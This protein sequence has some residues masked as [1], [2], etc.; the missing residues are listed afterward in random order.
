MTSPQPSQDADAQAH[1]QASTAPMTLTVAHCF[2]EIDRDP[3]HRARTAYIVV[4]VIRA[5]T[6]LA[7]MFEHGARR[8]LVARDVDAARAVRATQPHAILAG[9]VNAVAPP[10]FD[11]GNS[12]QEWSAVDVADREIL[13]ST[14]NGAHAL[15]AA[16]GGG[17]V[18]AGSL[19]NA[20]AVCAAALA[21]V[22]QLATPE[23]GGIVT[24]VCSGLGARPADDDSLCAG[25]LIQTLRD[26]ARRDH[27]GA[28]LGPGAQRALDLL[29]AQRAAFSQGEGQGADIAPRVWLAA[30]MRGTPAAQAVLAAGLGADLAWCANV[31]ASTVVPMIAGEDV[32][33]KLVIVERAPERLVGLPIGEEIR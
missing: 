18:F 14:S 31:D 1:T 4:D 29:A 27:V 28:E 20:R 13:F 26:E 6:T 7:V 9:E 25:W 32:S 21:A 2:D 3:A 5:T 24:V 22:R 11:H 10:D 12:P 33:R 19:R 16:L 8:V 17:P 15:H 30:A 23:Q